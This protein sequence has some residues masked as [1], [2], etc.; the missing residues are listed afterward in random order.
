MHFFEVLISQ[1]AT[2]QEEERRIK[3]TK[4]DAKDAKAQSPTLSQQRREMMKI[5]AEALLK[6][7]G[8]T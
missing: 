8:H 7:A 1:M 6:R 2:A 5:T 3:R 4:V